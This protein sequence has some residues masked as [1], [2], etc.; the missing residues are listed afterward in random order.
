MDIVHLFYWGSSNFPMRRVRRG[1][2]LWQF[3][4]HTYRVNLLRLFRWPF[5][6]ANM[7]RHAK[8]YNPSRKIPTINRQ[9]ILSARPDVS[10]ILFSNMTTY[11]LCV[12]VLYWPI[13]IAKC[14]IR[15][16]ARN[17]LIFS[18]IQRMTNIRYHSVD[19]WTFVDKINH[20]RQ[21]SATIRLAPSVRPH[22]IVTLDDA[23]QH[24]HHE[25][26]SSHRF[27]QLLN[28]PMTNQRLLR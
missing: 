7:M 14:C 24:Y 9:L 5:N 16:I 12:V 10:V 17:A 18:S 27:A 26:F 23:N 20:H 15:L 13:S 25:S 28:Q 4:P 2:I 6:G 22:K 1:K 3:K 11:A 8:D 21:C 19:L